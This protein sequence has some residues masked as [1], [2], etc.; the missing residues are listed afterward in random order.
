MH[1]NQMFVHTQLA[2]NV[3]RQSS[4]HK[5]RRHFK[6][7]CLRQLTPANK[8]TL[9]NRCLNLYESVQKLCC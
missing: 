3:E 4:Q 5:E 9:Q 8:K 2:V 1:K 6:F 7:R